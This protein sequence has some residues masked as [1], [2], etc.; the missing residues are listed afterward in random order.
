[1]RPNALLKISFLVAL[2]FFVACASRQKPEGATV[3]PTEADPLG[4]GEDQPTAAE[5]ESP[6][7][8]PPKDAPEGERPDT[9][10]EGTTKAPG[11]G[12]PLPE[13]CANL[14]VVPAKADGALRFV[15][16]NTDGG[17]KELRQDTLESNNSLDLQEDHL[18]CLAGLIVKMQADVVFLSEVHS[19]SKY[20]NKWDMAEA[21]RSMA[22]EISPGWSTVFGHSCFLPTE[23]PSPEVGRTGNAFIVRDRSSNLDLGPGGF[24]EVDYDRNPDDGLERVFSVAL[25]TEIPAADRTVDD[26]KRKDRKCYANP[27]SYTRNRG[28]QKSAIMSVAFG[29]EIVGVHLSP[30]KRNMDQRATQLKRL[31]KA[32]R[33]FRKRVDEQLGTTDPRPSVVMGDLNEGD[34]VFA[35]FK[36]YLPEEGW[37]NATERIKYK[38]KL[39]HIFIRNLKLLHAAH[40]HLPGFLNHHVMYAD[41]QLNA[42]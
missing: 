19:Y 37:Q 24:L 3:K 36:E 31:A 21:I 38:K 13:R 16:I 15:T 30:G 2:F 18:R 34:V 25:P 22:E 41:V 26:K 23:Q 39:D 1:M 6:T 5:S 12:F 20:W 42:K 11:E 35:L 10:T 33:T 27:D 28:R 32:V 17:T 7:E 29:V 4:D 8:G 14:P 9:E 40:L